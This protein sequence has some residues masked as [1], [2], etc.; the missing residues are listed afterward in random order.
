MCNI[1][2]PLEV[3]EDFWH[4][5]RFNLQVEDAQCTNTL[6]ETSAEKNVTR[7]KAL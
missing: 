2:Q 1:D 3:S 6:A 4:H 5:G 7:S